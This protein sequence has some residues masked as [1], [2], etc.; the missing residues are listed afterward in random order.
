MMEKS[1]QNRPQTARGKQTPGKVNWWLRMTSTG[2]D[3]PQ[4]TIEQREITRRSQLLSWILLGTFVAML[5]FIPALFKDTPS[6]FAVCG[7]LIGLVFITFFNRRGW[8]TLA[9]VLMVLFDIA[10]SLSVIV[11]AVDGQIHVVTL[12]AY[13]FLVLPVIVG[14]SILPRFSAFIIAAF[15]I[16]LIYA[17][18]IFQKHAQDLQPAIQQYG[19]PVLA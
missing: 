9:G 2:W 10:A 17:D 5:A 6:V 13:D 19:L 8:I 14:A 16:G 1:I 15:N 18:L 4:E 12:P 11:G 7:M 3:K